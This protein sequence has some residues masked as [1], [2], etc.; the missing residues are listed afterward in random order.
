MPRAG[1]SESR[2]IDEA[3]RFADEVGLSGLTLAA[4]AG[5]LGVRQPS[6]Y[7]H[8]DGMD[9][10]QRSISVRA[11][12]E[13]ADTMARAAVGRA[14]DDAIVAMAR[15]YREWAVAHP[16]RYAAAQ[17]APAPGDVDD[18]AAS[19][20][21]VRVVADVLSGYQLRDDDAVDAVRALR[22]ALHGFVLLETGGGFGLPVDVDRSFERLVGALVIAL[23]NWRNGHLVSPR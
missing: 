3:E 13:L 7:K 8:I 21:A 11:K 5:R 23:S 12:Y 16:G 4:L 17:H 10:L 9:G 1:L 6:L 15:A 14:C 22:S 19:Q 2:V 20:A 18:E